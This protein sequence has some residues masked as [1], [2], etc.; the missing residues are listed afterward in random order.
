MALVVTCTRPGLIRGGVR[1][2]R[3]ASYADGHFSP[4]QLAELLAEPEIVV[5]RGEVVTMEELLA[6]GRHAAMAE[7]EN[8]RIAVAGVKRSARK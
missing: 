6:L 2:P 8:A 4:E 7:G 3:A 5:V 1:H